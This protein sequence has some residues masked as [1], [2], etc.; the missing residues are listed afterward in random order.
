MG[1]GGVPHEAELGGGEVLVFEKLLSG[2]LP[3]D[4]IV[5]GRK[6]DLEGTSF[7]G[8]AG[9]AMPVIRRNDE[10]GLFIIQ[11]DFV[12]PFVVRALEEYDEA[13]ALKRVH[14]FISRVD[15]SR[16]GFF[17]PH[18]DLADIDLGGSRTPIFSLVVQD[19]D[20]AVVGVGLEEFEFDALCDCIEQGEDLEGFLWHME[21]AVVLCGRVMCL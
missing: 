6:D 18:R 17:V 10:L 1:T 3:G 7:A 4:I 13:A 16:H 12:G 5:F 19:L 15:M 9:N 20:G 14:L 11:T 8:Q 21:S 2:V